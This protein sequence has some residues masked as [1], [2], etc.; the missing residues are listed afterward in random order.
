MEQDS[1]NQAMQEQRPNKFSYWLIGFIS[2]VVIGIGASLGIYYF[3]KSKQIDNLCAPFHL[4]AAGTDFVPAYPFEY[5][6]YWVWSAVPSEAPMMYK[7]SGRFP[8]SRGMNFQAYDSATTLPGHTIVDQDIV[9]DPG[10]SNPFL[11]GVN[12]YV[13]DR[14]YTVWFVP[15]AYAAGKGNVLIMPEGNINAT[16]IMRIIHHDP[17]DHLPL[18][19]IRA[20]NA[21]TGEPVSCPRQGLPAGL[22]VA[23]QAFKEL[24][25]IQVPVESPTFEFYRY[26]PDRFIPNTSTHYLTAALASPSAGNIAAVWYRVPSF[27]DTYNDP[28]AVFTGSE[29]VRHSGICIHGLYS[30]IGMECLVDH[31]FAGDM[32]Y[33]IVGPDDD[34]VRKEAERRGYKYL[35]WGNFRYPLIMYRQRQPRSDFA[36]SAE[37]VPFTTPAQLDPQAAA[38]HYMGEYAPRGRVCTLDAFMAGDNCGLPTLR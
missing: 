21:A 26:K 17:V 36:G 33:I 18:P 25:Q 30:T 34:T 16:M 15:A 37:K 27:A 9:P 1:T 11:P 7:I 8:F 4:S 6:K 5:T 13:E 10:S 29:D 23:V 14:S 19:T 31:E 28:K 35:H 2:V 12:R 22:S 20:F 24:F 38:V 32:A 3:I